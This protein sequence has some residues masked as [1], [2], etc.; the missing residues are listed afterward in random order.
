MFEDLVLE[1]ITK[2]N[3]ISSGDKIVVAVSGGPDSMALLNALINLK[4]K[5]NCEL[6]VCHVNHMIRVVADSETEYVQAFC[7]SKG[8]ECFVKKVDVLSLANEQKIGTEE[9]GRNVRYEFFD[10]VFDKVNANKIV[11]AHNANDNAETVLM[12]VLR[13]AGISGLKGIEPVRDNKFIR[14][15]IEIERADIEKYCEDMKLDPK[16]DESNKDNTYTRNKIRN[17]LIPFLKDEFNPSI[18]EGLNR[19]SDLAS[20]ENKYVESI[21]DKE[22]ANILVST[23]SGEIVLNLK[24]F[25]ALDEFIKGRIILL[26]VFNLFGSTK[27]IEKKHIEDIIKLCE[28]N[29]GNKYLTPNKNVKFFVGQG[30][31]VIT[32]Q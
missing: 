25:N 29:I 31:I 12:N 18:V 17:V 8:I 19:L 26:C 1:T 28:R 32:R 22:Y 6:V 23:D 24:E 10:E 21:V 13:G 30:N 11:I 4:E 16:F 7:A 2:Y 20:Q 3:M 14:P 9:A 15:L 5:L 27:G